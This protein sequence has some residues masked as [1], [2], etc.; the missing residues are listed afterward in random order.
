MA[1]LA[2]TSYNCYHIVVVVVVLLSDLLEPSPLPLLPPASALL[3][4]PAVAPVPEPAPALAT[5]LPL[6][7]PV[8]AE[9]VPRLLLNKV[10]LEGDEAV[11]GGH[12]QVDRLAQEAVGAAAADLVGAVESGGPLRELGLVGGEFGLRKG[13]GAALR[14]G[15]TGDDGRGGGALLV[16]LSGGG[17]RGVQA[18][19]RLQGLLN[20][21][22]LGELE[23][24]H[25]LGNDGALM[26]GL[27]AGHKLGLE[28]AGLLGV[29]VAHFLRNVHKRGN[30]LLVTLLRS[31][32]SDTASTTNLNWQLFT[33]GVTNKLARLL[34]NITSGARRLIDSPALFRSLAIADLFQGL[35][36]LLHC[37]I[38]GLLLEGD[39]TGLLKVLFADLF[40]SRGELCHIGVVALLHVLVGT[41]QD[42]VL[43]ERGDG[44]LPLHA[45]EAGVG[46][47]DTPT[48]VDAAIDVAVKLAAPPLGVGEPVGRGQSQ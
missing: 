9:G 40:L 39:L 47:V 35:V 8:A 5:A 29:Q 13:V 33:T 7:P 19:P 23:V 14:P 24:A 22:G 28:A 17:L 36:A 15:R 26:L 43:L 21:L 11:D 37:F 44:L 30:H 12:L 4:P 46:I 45:A 32:L 20:L 6:L 41:L 31:F 18:P 16:R 38:E 2:T 10:A 48:E 42:G 25:L 3:L 1:P 34:L 27:E